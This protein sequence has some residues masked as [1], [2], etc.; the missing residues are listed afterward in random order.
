MF[1]GSFVLGYVKK[2][3]I[4]EKAHKFQLKMQ[5]LIKDSVTNKFKPGQCIASFQRSD[6]LEKFEKVFEET[7][8]TLKSQV[9]AKKQEETKK[10]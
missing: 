9:P 3:R 6:H 4:K 7:M 10:E 1:Q 5:F 2:F 8:Q